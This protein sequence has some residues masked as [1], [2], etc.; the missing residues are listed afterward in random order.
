M[1]AYKITVHD[2]FLNVDLSGTFKTSSKQKAIA[3]C[4]DFYAYELDT[5]EDAINIVKIERIEL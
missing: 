2:D 4:K 3:E 5:T 1:T